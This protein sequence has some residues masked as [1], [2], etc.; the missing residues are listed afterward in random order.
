MLTQQRRSASDF[1]AVAP[2]AARFL[3]RA[4]LLTIVAHGAAM[5]TMALILLPGM[6]GGSN[7]L[8]ARVAY[9][10]ANPT[11]WR[12]GWLPWQITALSDLL[13]A[14]ALL[15]TPW[16]PRFPA[17]LVMLATLFAILNEQPNEFAWI[18][19]GVALA[20]SGDLAAYLQFEM[21]TYLPIAGWATI[22]YTIAACGWSWCFARAKT[23]SRGLT[24]LS[25]ITW[26]ILFAVGIAPLLPAADQPTAEI[27]AVGNALGFILMMIWLCMV[28]EMVLRRSRETVRYG[29]MALWCYPRHDLLEH[30][31]NLL[32]NSRLA[33]AFGEIFPSM[34]FISNI[35]DVIYVNY[36]VDTEVLVPL[37]P[38]GLEL[39]RLGRDGK[40]ALFTHLTYQHG[41][42]GPQML[43]PLRRLL[44]SPVQSNWRIYV[45]DPRTNFSGIYFVAT[46][47]NKT[48]PA[49]LARFLSEGIPMHLVKQA[50]VE[51]K[52]D[53]SFEVCLDP[54]IGSAPDLVMRLQPSPSMALPAVWSDCFATYHDL[55]AYCV[56][57]DRAMSSQLWYSHITRQEIE[58]GIPLEVCEPLTA[59]TLVSAAAQA[60]V[61][62]AQAVCFRVPQ[63]TLRF[64]HE[65]HDPLRSDLQS[66][67]VPAASPFAPRSSP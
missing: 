61:G 62:D 17:L 14:L 7:P 30:P 51:P 39:Q 26:G 38:P 37:V 6:P 46:A 25:C 56:P 31:L 59:V 60:L 58:L 21:R 42:F 48:L 65:E 36:I 18:T 44:P 20:Q 43:G 11:L 4:L 63:V 12:I 52:A 10:A 23:W 16:I 53:G 13:L 1:P 67:P 19:Q 55:L 34:A 29:R 45:R 28:S 33:R 15:R 47:I 49:L 22:G 41:H 2:L 57:Q 54:G 9:I 32:A 24:W 3:E 64:T 40:Q 27:I 66:R 5:L 35:T 8:A 50:K